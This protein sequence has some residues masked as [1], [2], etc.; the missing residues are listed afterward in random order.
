[1]SKEIQ[2]V[3]FVMP[4]HF[5]S[6]ERGKPFYIRCFGFWS[7]DAQAFVRFQS[8][9]NVWDALQAPHTSDSYSLGDSLKVWNEGFDYWDD[10]EYIL[11]KINSVNPTLSEQ[12][13]EVMSDFCRDAWKA[14]DK[15]EERGLKIIDTDVEVSK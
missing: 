13:F 5:E 14:S 9:D 10:I 7:Y 8:G 6:N 2:I 11:R 12:D 1:M 15:N 3:S 4:W